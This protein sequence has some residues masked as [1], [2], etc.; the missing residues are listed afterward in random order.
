M[1]T[2]IY[3]YEIRYWLR[4]P[5]FY[6]YSGLFV[7][8]ACLSIAGEAGFFDGPTVSIPSA[9]L[10]NSPFRLFSGISNFTMF[11]LFLLPAIIGTSI[12][13][14]VKYQLHEVLYSYPFTKPAYLFGKFLSAL[15]IVLLIL[16]GIGIGLIIGTHLPGL[17]AAKI[18]PLHWEVYGYL[19]LVY[20]I[21]N[22][23][24]FGAIVFTVVALT[25]NV[26]AGFISIALLY[27]VQGMIRS[28]L[29]EIDS[30][31]MLALLDPLGDSAI[32]Y[33]T[34]YWTM[35]DQNSLMLPLQSVI[36][37][38]RMLWLAISGLL[39]AAVYVRFD[40]S[41]QG[42]IFQWRKAIGKRSVKQNFGSI[43]RIHLPAVR[44]DFSCWQQVQ[45]S[46]RL[47]HI[48]LRYIITSLPF[49]S[50][51]L[52]GFLFVLFKNAA[53][54]TMMG[55]N[56]YPVTW[57][58][59]SFP[60]ALMGF[61][62]MILTF[63]YAGML[64][65]RARMA[66]LNQLVDVS[67][68][69]NWVLLS[70]KFLALIQMQ[71][72]LLALI[73]IGGISIQVYRGYPMIE[74][75]HYLFELY[76]LK[77]IGFIIW[78]FAALFIQTLFS[79]PY[80]GFF[81]LF[82][83]S[84]G[85]DQ[86]QLIGIEQSVFRFNDGDGYTYS[87][88]NGYGAFLGPYFAYKIYWS[89]AGMV[90]LIGAGLMWT[91]GLPHSFGERLRI[92]RS[93]VKPVASLTLVVLLLGFFAM[94]FRIYY[95]N[96]LRYSGVSSSKDE[97]LFL[98]RLEQKYKRY[99]QTVQPKITAVSIEM[100]IF[101]ETHDFQSNAEYVLV[102]RSEEVID[103]LLVHYA[104]NVISEFE[105]DRPTELVS[106]DS[107]LLFDIFT[108]A[109][110]LQPGDS[111]RM[112]STIRNQPNSFF[113]QNA[114]VR[115]NGS[116]LSS[117][118]Y[119]RLGYRDFELQNNGKRAQYG[120]P[121]TVGKALPTDSTAL[122]FTY[123][124]KDSDWIRF[125]ATVSTAE[126]QIALSPGY[127]QREWTDQGRRYF[128]YKMD[129][130]IKFAFG[131]NSGRYAVMRDQWK[132]VELAI[133]YHPEHDYNLDRMMKGLKASLAYNS[134]NFSPYQHKQARIIEFPIT[135]GT[136]ATVFANS[137]P[138]SEIRFISEVDDASEGG[139]VPFYVT[140]HEMAHQWWGNQV[141]PA[142][143]RGSRMIT[144]GLAEY[145]SLQVVKFEQGEVRMRQL[146]RH[147]REAYLRGRSRERRQETSLRYTFPGQD[148][149]N[150]RKAAV[151]FCTLVDYLGEMKLNAALQRYLLAVQY[152][153]A[154][155]TNSLQLIDS[156]RAATP[157]SLQYLIVDL[158]ETVT[159]YDNRVEKA[160]VQQRADG[161]FQIEADLTIRKYRM[162]TAESAEDMSSSA[163]PLADY[164]EIAIMGKV[165]NEI[166]RKMHKI[167]D[168]NTH[169]SLIV[170]EVPGSVVIDPDQ[171]L[172]DLEETDNELDF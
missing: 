34:R 17:N 55:T 20:I 88:L 40:F 27:L 73:M 109:T 76:A 56:S 9:V 132:E 29:G 13:R 140:V 156:L 116:F 52:A 85:I 54:T 147:Q 126:D 131:F 12:N 74:A 165:G 121:P 106:R 108:L 11:I 39:F 172:I 122:L 21:P 26:Y 81:L 91:R 99:A 124:S 59:L 67:P 171:R 167:T 19:Y 68:I 100:D 134:T 145:V 142:D 72:L 50:I 38:N 77:W 30:A 6:I 79:N 18:G 31:I 95:E 120:L 60:A 92:A 162:D 62:I 44:Y 96:N 143:V 97:T 130:P 46:W 105:F 71:A 115:S 43:T 22:V 128:Q 69:P 150:Y 118:I 135:E 155:F 16:L 168:S 166:Y 163:L 104:M 82:I 86:L 83:G 49:I 53:G 129:V 133:Y 89:L 65:H 101:P 87:D 84:M 154:P 41:Q 42:P 93:R 58:M 35:E 119:P 127:L 33:Y 114:T 28:S 70:S 137:I 159:L 4:Q 10:I 32:Q 157:D 111:M 8:A 15:T 75:G 24:F 112:I 5:A 123:Q 144:E 3:L 136:F 61:V 23:V 94:G 51:T 14:E 103:T 139:D 117:N 48:D 170:A 45:A 151:A 78:A 138:F 37:Y 153:S 107:V 152:Q 113:R 63:L 148:Y 141:I 1:F 47:S 90:L 146:L 125:E 80:L 160:S 2:P 102:N 169:L 25:R 158:F 7:L 36:L 149:V 164:I 110:G 161:K 98:V 57:L 64:V 66:R